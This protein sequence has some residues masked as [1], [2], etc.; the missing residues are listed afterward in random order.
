MNNDKAKK[1]R[2]LSRNLI[3]IFRRRDEYYIYN[4]HKHYIYVL[5]R[6][7]NLEDLE[8]YIIH[9]DKFHVITSLDILDNDGVSQQLKNL[10][11]DNIDMFSLKIQF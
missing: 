5:G 3:D 7:N 6:I 1:S 8:F 9:N 10:I 11:W 2:E 4:D